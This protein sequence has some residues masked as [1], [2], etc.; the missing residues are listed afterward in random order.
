MTLASVLQNRPS[1]CE[2]LVVQPRCYDDPYGL[3]GEVRFI[4]APP[5]SSLAEIINAGLR[6]VQSPI[7]HLLSCDVE[8]AEDW[9]EPALS[10]FSDP[11]VG[12]VSPLLTRCGDC[13]LAVARGIRYGAGGLPWLDCREDVNHSGIE[14]VVGPTLHAA[15]Y[16]SWAVR[17]VAEFCVEVGEELADVDMALSLKAIGLRAVHEEASVVRVMSERRAISLSMRS[18]RFAERVFW[19]HAASFGWKKSLL[20]HPGC[21]AVELLQNIHRPRIVVR[22]LGRLLAA[23]DIPAQLRY[24]ERLTSAGRAWN[25]RRPETGRGAALGDQSPDEPGPGAKRRAAAAA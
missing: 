4:E 16:R 22:T 2:I 20:L 23:A 5:S 6:Q 25:I 24:R 10:H 14:A 15:F 18:G 13:G 21:I 9:T 19:R 11:S 12:S 3:A 7:V 17:D 1:S 8:V